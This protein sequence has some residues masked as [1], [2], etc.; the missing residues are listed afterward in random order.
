MPNTVLATQ[1]DTTTAA[2]AKFMKAHFTIIFRSFKQT[3]HQDG[4]ARAAGWVS[5]EIQ[6]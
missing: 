4:T 5:S 2:S 3:K 6:L 1:T